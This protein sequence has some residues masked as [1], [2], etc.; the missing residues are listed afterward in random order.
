MEGQALILA[1]IGRTYASQGDA[2]KALDYLDRAHQL[3]RDI[4]ADWITV[5]V[6]RTKSRV[7]AQKGAWEK[8]FEAA[9]EA[10]SLAEILGSDEDLGAVYRLLG[11]IA[12]AWE[13]SN[14]GAPEAY[15]TQSII[16]LERVGEQ[17]EIQ[18]SLDSFERY[19]ISTGE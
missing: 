3:S 18:R 9:T 13:E 17:Y 6:W 4:R 11:E 5:K 7:F 10:K 16:I 12:A 14:L 8:A 1:N 15:F 2:E 19:K